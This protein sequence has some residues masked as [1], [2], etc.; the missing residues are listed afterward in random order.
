MLPGEVEAPG[1]RMRR[2]WRQ[3]ERSARPMGWGPPDD[4]RAFLNT[5]ALRSLPVSKAGTGST[6]CLL[7]N[8]LPCSHSVGA[9]PTVPATGPHPTRA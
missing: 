7:I 8:F 6:G 4:R 1:I 5:E 3:P 9:V 2:P